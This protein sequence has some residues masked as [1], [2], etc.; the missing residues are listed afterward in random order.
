MISCDSLLLS[1]YRIT[2]IL[3]EP[4]ISAH[5][6]FIHKWDF[7][8]CLFSKKH[9]LAGRLCTHNTLLSHKLHENYSNLDHL[10]SKIQNL[11]ICYAKKDIYYSKQVIHCLIPFQTFTQK[12]NRYSTF[13]KARAGTLFKC[14][15]D[16]SHL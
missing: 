6:M 15:F 8:L 3:T 1:T 5:L 13:Q 14:Q 4:S 9:S 11:G 2:T 10:P 7:K 16:F 12:L